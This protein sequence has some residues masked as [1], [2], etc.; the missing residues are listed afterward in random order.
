MTAHGMIHASEL[1]GNP[2]LYVYIV[3]YLSKTHRDMLGCMIKHYNGNTQ[4][5]ELC[6]PKMKAK[7]IS[8]GTKQFPGG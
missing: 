3:A 7:E 5:I 2:R 4:P 1:Q 8:V 6:G